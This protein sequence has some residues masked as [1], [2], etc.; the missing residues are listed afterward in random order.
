M[1]NWFLSS[2]SSLLT[3]QCQ[4]LFSSFLIYIVTICFP[5]WYTFVAYRMLT[6]AFTSAFC[7]IRCLPELLIT[8]FPCPSSSSEWESSVFCAAKPGQSTDAGSLLLV[9][10]PNG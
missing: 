7:S 1:I 10:R 8:N 6:A 3:Y 5:A 4:L 9:A 2:P